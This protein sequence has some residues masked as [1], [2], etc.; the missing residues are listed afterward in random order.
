MALDPEI[1]ALIEAARAIPG[2][3]LNEMS[4][5]EARF[6]F[7]ARYRTRSVP[8]VRD[9]R[10]DPVF[11]PSSDG[12]TIG[13]RLYRPRMPGSAP[14][15][16]AI[17]LHGGGFVVGSAEG[18]EAQSTVFADR[19]RCLVLFPEFRLAPEHPFPAAIEDAIATANWV[20]A[21]AAPLGVDPGRIAVIGD[22]AG[23][24][25]AA[26]ICLAARDRGGPAIALQCLIYPV[27]DFRPYV[28][29]RSYPSV[30]S[31]STGHW[32]DH[33]LMEWFAQLYLRG[34][35]DAEDPRASPILAKNLGNLPPTLVI[36]AECDPLRDMGEAFAEGLTAAGTPTV[37]RC[38]SGMVHNFLGLSDKSLVA[39]RVLEDIADLLRERLSARQSADACVPVC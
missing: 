39:R 25:L 31:F 10:S 12:V 14:L 28:G 9:V 15:P 38:V 30:E 2:R 16:I 5:G 17:Y 24:N 11:I 1:L 37:Y 33:T 18:Y 7:T 13:A 4:L 21:N 19:G 35:A 6:Y 8:A 22:S 3:A 26:N 29:G 23:G 20:V 36:T 32:L 27:T 34:T